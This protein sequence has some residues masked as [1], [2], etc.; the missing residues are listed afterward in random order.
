MAD[1]GSTD[2]GTAGSDIAT[3]TDLRESRPFRRGAAW[4]VHTRFIGVGSWAR[5]CPKA[6][7]RDV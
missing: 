5:A 3:E 2:E 4:R 7:A 6:D 1:G